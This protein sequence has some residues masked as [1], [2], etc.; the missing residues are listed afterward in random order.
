M[1]DGEGERRREGGGASSK[2]TTSCLNLRVWIAVGCSP[3]PDLGA[4]GR[5]VSEY[6]H[7]EGDVGVE[8]G[9]REY[10]AAGGRAGADR[11]VTDR[12]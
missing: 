3:V 7:A 11:I 5:G 4:R 6:D 10:L 12:V 9:G 2:L 8:T 1:P